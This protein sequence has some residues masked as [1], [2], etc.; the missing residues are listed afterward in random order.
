MVGLGFHLVTPRSARCTLLTGA[1]I[2]QWTPIEG[3][4][5]V[6]MIPVS[7]THGNRCQ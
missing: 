6:E 7:N 4:F 2:R 1:L 5:S 3:R